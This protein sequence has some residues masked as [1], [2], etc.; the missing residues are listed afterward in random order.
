MLSGH[1]SEAIRVHCIRYS[2]HCHA[3]RRHCCD[4]KKT[5]IMRIYN[6]TTLLTLTAICKVVFD[7]DNAAA[8]A[9]RVAGLAVPEELLSCFGFS[10]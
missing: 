9:A 4:A 5:H 7:A 2:K 10:A 6:L 3:I 1:F 8:D